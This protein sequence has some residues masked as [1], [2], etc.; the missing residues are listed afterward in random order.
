MSKNECVKVV[1]RCRPLNSTEISDSRQVIVA[2]DEKRGE[3][4]IQNLK[5]DT[6]EAEK[7][8]AF[9]KVFDSNSN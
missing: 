4:K 9:D 7:V 1:V 8:F 6:G 2:V 5:G 3:I